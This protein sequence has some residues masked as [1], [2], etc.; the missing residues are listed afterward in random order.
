MPKPIQVFTNIITARHFVH[1]LR[2]I[3]LKESGIK[4][5]AIQASILAVFTV[6]VLAL[7]VKKFRK[8]IE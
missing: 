5:I 3:Y 8:R 4:E 1:I 2:G 6:A 7:A